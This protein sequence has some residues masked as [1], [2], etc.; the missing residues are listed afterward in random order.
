MK[1]QATRPSCRYTTMMMIQ[2]WDTFPPWGNDDH[3]FP[4]M[5]LDATQPRNSHIQ[6]SE[7]HY[8]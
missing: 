5:A 7:L 2:R 6:I 4:L 3:S 1:H 8:D